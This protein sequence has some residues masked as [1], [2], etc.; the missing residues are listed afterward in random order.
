METAKSDNSDDP[1]PRIEPEVVPKEIN[2][3]RASQLKQFVL[4]PKNE[5]PTSPV[6]SPQMKF[7]VNSRSS[8]GR[9]ILGGTGQQRSR[10]NMLNLDLR[11]EYVL[12]PQL[13]FKD[14]TAQTGAAQ[15]RSVVHLHHRGIS[16]DLLESRVI[17]VLE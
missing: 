15:K 7:R 9:L 10:A 2:I 12:S 8:R 17:S 16:P 6:M 14:S 3:M 5:V 13:G 4:V 11:Q 1:T